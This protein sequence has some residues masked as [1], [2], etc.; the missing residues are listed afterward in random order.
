MKRDGDGNCVCINE[1]VLASASDPAVCNLTC[2]ARHEPVK[3]QFK[4][5]YDEG[6]P[7]LYQDSSDTVGA[8]ITARRIIIS[9]DADG[10][11]WD[12]NTLIPLFRPNVQPF[13]DGVIIQDTNRLSLSR[14]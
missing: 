9:D 13:Y 4:V 5:V 8:P 2:D 12:T 14:N 11:V 7:R 1:G 10:T 6:F 3:P